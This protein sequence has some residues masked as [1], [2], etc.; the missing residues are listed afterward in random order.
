MSKKQQFNY[1]YYLNKPRFIEKYNIDLNI[2]KSLA[3]VIPTQQK[4]NLTPVNKTK[5]MPKADKKH[6]NSFIAV[7]LCGGKAVRFNNQFKAVFEIPNALTKDISLTFLELNIKQII[8]YENKHKVIVPVVIYDDFATRKPIRK[9]LKSKNYFGKNKNDFV[10]V[11]QTS[12]FRYIP[13]MEMLKKLNLSEQISKDMIPNLP[14]KSEVYRSRRI[15]DS[16]VGTGHFV[17]N[18]LMM[19]NKFINLIKN[20]L[21]I[22]KI[23]VSNCDNIGKKYYSDLAMNDG[24][25]YSVVTD[26]KIDE[27]MDGVYIDKGHNEIIPYFREGNNKSILGFTGTLYLSIDT[28]LSIFGIKNI[29][30]INLKT[31]LN[32]L[33]NT[34]TPVIKEIKTTDGNKITVHYESVLSDISRFVKINPVF[35]KRN[36]CFYP[37]KRIG[38][39]NETYISKWRKS[40]K[41]H[42]YI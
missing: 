38:D 7:I 31:S 34:Y 17:F 15:M 19:S 21:D 11:M 6:S 10:H 27:K 14:L 9:L 39:V 25:N 1:S 24:L 29:K 36:L 3:M 13:N 4:T 16:I 42:K 41:I 33:S 2:E 20:R 18:S 5:E 32:Y 8:C 22:T 37:F 12:W 40:V 30:S 23:V 28:M 26:R 35:V